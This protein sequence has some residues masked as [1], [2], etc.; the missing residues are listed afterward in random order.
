MEGKFDRWKN[1][2]VRNKDRKEWEVTPHTIMGSEI[3]RKLLYTPINV[4]DLGYMKDLG[5]PGMV[6]RQGN[7]RQYVSGQG[8]TIPPL[9]GAGV[10]QEMNR[11]FKFL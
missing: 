10:P 4:A 5:Y 2:I 8:F 7:P 9:P 11:R 1:T 6:L 3:T